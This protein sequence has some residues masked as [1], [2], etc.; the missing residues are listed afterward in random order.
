MVLS[1]EHSEDMF[2]QLREKTYPEKEGDA[3]NA[4]EHASIEGAGSYCSR[5]RD[6]LRR[7]GGDPAEPWSESTS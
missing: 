1:A 3:G 4:A 5:H 6:G 7:H 2:D